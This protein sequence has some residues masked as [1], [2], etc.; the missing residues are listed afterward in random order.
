MAERGTV[1]LIDV[2]KRFGE[3]L[4]ISNID[5][6]LPGGAYCCLLGP[7]GC[8]KTTILRMVAGHETPSEGQIRIDGQDVTGLPPVERGTSMMFSV[9]VSA[10][11]MKKPMSDAL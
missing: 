9:R 10:G 6:T 8:G 2:T 1:D 7:S 4:A 11:T 5:L 3:T